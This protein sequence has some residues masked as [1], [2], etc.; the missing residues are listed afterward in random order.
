MDIVQNNKV[1]LIE[2]NQLVSKE[3]N[4][5]E[6]FDIL[7]KGLTQTID[8]D[9]NTLK[10]TGI[11]S[12]LAHIITQIDMLLID[13]QGHS[14]ILKKLKTNEN[15]L[16]PSGREMKKDKLSLNSTKIRSENNVNNALSFFIAEERINSQLNPGFN[17]SLSDYKL[18]L[19]FNKEEEEFFLKDEFTKKS[20]D[21]TSKKLS[22]KEKFKQSN[23]LESPSDKKEHLGNFFNINLEKKLIKS[24]ST[25]KNGEIKFEEAVRNIEENGA[26]ELKNNETANSLVLESVQNKTVKIIERLKEIKESVK[27]AQFC[28]GDFIEKGTPKKTDNDEDKRDIIEEF[29]Y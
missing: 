21:L 28:L 16:S 2:F 1:S 8:Q 26:S 12:H 13:L 27:S 9:N 20:N 25:Q 14:I 18:P 5:L 11:S 7:N 23:S 15:S 24:K 10:L 29:R 3:P 22:T 4:L 17:P 6:V 19:H